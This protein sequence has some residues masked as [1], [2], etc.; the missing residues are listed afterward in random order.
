MKIYSQ[1]AIFASPLLSWD[2]SV[3]S[4]EVSLDNIMSNEIT[5][6]KHY[7]YILSLRNHFPDSAGPGTGL[8]P[9]CGSFQHH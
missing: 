8:F 4:T 3:F 2:A 1:G 5:Y 6:I 9:G 7:E